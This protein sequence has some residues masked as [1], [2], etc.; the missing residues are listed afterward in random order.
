VRPDRV[1]R[2]PPY[3]KSEY[4]EIRSD[5]RWFLIARLHLIPDVERVVSENDRYTVV[6]KRE[7]EAAEVAIGTDPRT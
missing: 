2:L 1:R 4:E 6:A 5:P 3:D 7:G